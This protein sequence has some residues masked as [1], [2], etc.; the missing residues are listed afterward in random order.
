L[1]L[2]IKSGGAEAVNLSVS[3]IEEAWRTSLGRKLQAEVIAAVAE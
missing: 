2:S 1:S 3:E